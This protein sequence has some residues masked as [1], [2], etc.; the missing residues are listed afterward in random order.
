MSSQP[1]RVC[2][3][4]VLPRELLRQRLMVRR[5]GRLRAINPIGKKWMNGERLCVRF[6]G[7][8][9]VQQEI[10][11]REAGWW[12]Q[13]A[14]LM[15]KFDNASAAQIRISFDE[16]DGAWSYIGTDCQSIPLNQATMNLGF[17]DEGTTAHEFGHAI[18]LAHEHQNPAGGIQWNEAVVIREMAKSPNY[19]DEETTR[20]NV[21]L[22]Y[23]ADQINGTA[24]DPKSIMLYFFPPEWTLNGIATEA[25]KMLS[26]LDRQFISG[27]KMYPKTAPTLADAT[28]LEVNAKQGTV[29]SVGKFGEENVFTFVVERAGKH[30]IETSGQTD[31]V[32]KL[33]GPNKSTLLIA[34][35]DDSGVDYNARIAVDLIEGRYYVQVRHYSPR[36]KGDYSISVRRV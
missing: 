29:A 11:K 28:E 31:V 27:A 2:F 35:D 8:T 5:A 36:G 6:M 3:D 1:A 7:G 14:N 10:V 13:V 18:G 32:M 17:L 22:K 16:S 12:T 19:W 25:N 30:A 15:F 9:T 21:L 24:F 34:E 23:S 26:N 33:F 20:H 4:R